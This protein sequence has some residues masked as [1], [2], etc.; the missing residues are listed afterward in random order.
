MYFSDTQTTPAIISEFTFEWQTLFLNTLLRKFVNMCTL[1][2][3][4]M[5]GGFC[6]F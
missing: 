5:L 2:F 3:R 4:L 1:E 6:L